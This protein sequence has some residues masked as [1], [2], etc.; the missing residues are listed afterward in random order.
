MSALPLRRVDLR[1]ADARRVEV[2][3]APAAGR[4]PRIGARAV[5]EGLVARGVTTIF[6]YPGGAVLPIYDVLREFPTRHVLVRHEQGAAHAA[7][8]FSRATGGVGVALATS[9]PG[10]IH[11]VTGLAPARM[12]SVPMV[13][14]TGNVG[15]PFLGRDAFQET[16]IVGIA[17]PV[18]KFA[19]LVMDPD[20]GPP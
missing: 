5:L 13:A 17:L 11:L 20:E 9:G 4:A 3:P 18:T 1:Q 12:D 7:D 8:G 14:I 6:G 2:R 10:A 19:T 16:D 15:R